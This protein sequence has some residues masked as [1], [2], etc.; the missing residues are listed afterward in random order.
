MYAGRWPI[1]REHYFTNCT[2]I[3]VSLLKAS[4]KLLAGVLFLWTQEMLPNEQDNCGWEIVIHFLTSIL[5]LKYFVGRIC[6]NNL[7]FI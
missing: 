7:M 2:H 1:K 5:I 4:G 6:E 3:I